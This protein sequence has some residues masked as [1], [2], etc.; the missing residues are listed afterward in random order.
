M[1]NAGGHRAPACA[2]LATWRKALFP[3]EQLLLLLLQPTWPQSAS[4]SCPCRA[5][6]SAKAVSV[7]LLPSPASAASLQRRRIAHSHSSLSA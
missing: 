3:A 1:G 7:H 5:I 6:H 4:K 2:A